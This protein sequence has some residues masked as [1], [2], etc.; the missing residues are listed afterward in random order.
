MKCVFSLD[1][2]CWQYRDC[3]EYLEDLN[4]YFDNFKVSLFTIPCF[5][6]TPLSLHWEYLASVKFK[7]EHILHGYYHTTAEFQTLNKIQSRDYIEKGIEEFKKCGIPILPGFKGPN[8][9]YG[10]GLVEQ[11]KSMK[12]W[13]ATYRP[14]DIEGLKTYN[15]NWDIGDSMIPNAEIIHAHGHTHSLSGPG[16]GIQDSMDNFKR[17][18]KDT[19]FLFISEVM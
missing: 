11:L 9:R 3:I 17:L 5:E 6:E 16:K 15:W 2:Y 19:E 12:F 8:W 18:P 10:D 4:E 13:L 1:D 14:V 7:S